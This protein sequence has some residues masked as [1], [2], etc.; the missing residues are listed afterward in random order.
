MARSNEEGDPEKAL[1]ALIT[2]IELGRQGGLNEEHYSSLMDSEKRASVP[3]GWLNKVMPSIKKMEEYSID[4]LKMLESLIDEVSQSKMNQSSDFIKVSKGLKLRIEVAIEMAELTAGQNALKA[5]LE[6]YIKSQELE[7]QDQVDP[8]NV[9]DKSTKVGP[10]SLKHSIAVKGEQTSD[11]SQGAVVPAKGEGDNKPPKGSWLGW[12]WRA[13][14][15]NIS[16]PTAS[17]EQRAA[18]LGPYDPKKVK[19]IAQDV[20]EYKGPIVIANPEKGGKNRT[21]DEHK[22]AVEEKREKTGYRLSLKK[23]RLPSFK[24]TT[25]NNKAPKAPGQNSNRK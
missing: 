24:A 14:P 20:K 21:L 13:G 5:G 1:Q 2:K 3:M 22:K 19:Q 8:I 11:N 15:E 23:Q 4:E 7:S 25:E 12:R 10:Q 17:A 6:G 18:M 16:A 9:A